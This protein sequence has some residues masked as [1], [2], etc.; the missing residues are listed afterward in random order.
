VLAV[1]VRAARRPVRLMRAGSVEKVPRQRRGTAEE[2]LV[3]VAADP[4]DRLR[5]KQ[6]RS[7]GIQED[8]DVRSA[9]AQHPQAGERARGDAAQI[10]KPPRHTANG[11]HQWGGTSLQLVARK[12]S[13]PP[14]MPA[15]KPNSATS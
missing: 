9:A 1:P 13:R 10:P 14:M 15:G 4:T 7:D 12:Y 11:P 2:L 3:E 6:R 8:R 5:D